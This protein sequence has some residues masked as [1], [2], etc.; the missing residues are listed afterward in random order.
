MTS[1]DTSAAAAWRRCDAS[2]YPGL[3]TR[4]AT[5]WSS[6]LLHAAARDIE[7]HFLQRGAV[8]AR[9]DT[10]RRIVVLDPAS[11]QDDDTVAQSLDLEHVVRSKQDRRV[12]LL[13]VVFHVAPD[14]V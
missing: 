8:V 9:Q 11:L 4:P 12:V 2:R 5:R 14:P 7:E 6:L 10:G 1:E 3:R 13:A